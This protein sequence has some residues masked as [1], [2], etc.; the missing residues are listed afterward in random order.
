MQ[1]FLK[2]AFLTDP[3]LI[4]PEYLPLAS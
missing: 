1:A 3:N 2:K 4:R